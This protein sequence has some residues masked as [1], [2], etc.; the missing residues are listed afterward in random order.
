[1]PSVVPQGAR[2]ALHGS[3]EMTPL[4]F[5]A[6]RLP[7]GIGRF[8]FFGAVYRSGAFHLLR[9]R[10]SAAGSKVT[11]AMFHRVADRDPDDS[12][13][14]PTL[15]ISRR[16]F[17]KTIDFLRAHYRIISLDD[18]LEALD[19]RREL[20]PHSMVL[21]FDDAYAD[22]F[23]NAV[24]ALAERSVPATVFVPT[25]FVGAADRLFWW[26]ECYFLLRR[27]SGSPGT[28]RGALIRLGHAEI[29]DWLESARSRPLGDDVLSLVHTLQSMPDP[30][31]RSLLDVLWEQTGLPRAPLLA[32]NAMADWSTI[33]RAAA[34][35]IT[36]GSH[37]C[38]HLF[39]DCADSQTIRDE[40]SRSKR[41]I[42]GQLDRPVHTFAYPGGKLTSEV[43]RWVEEAG[44][45][46]GVTTEPGLNGLGDSPYTLK[47]ISIWNGTVSGP[48]GGFSPGRLAFNL[49][50]LRKARGDARRVRS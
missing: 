9:S 43:E 15:F 30:G 10:L 8:L 14:L 32:C 40:L 5:E 11:I 25:D 48:G 45:R 19:G 47:R 34:D 36:Y 49:L 16:R 23:E 33:R 27:L 39:L 35:G 3:D 31:R 7:A 13:S 28:V 17:E 37:T 4:R 38:S 29:V 42:E 6:G 24:P 26:D 20:A 2:C 44:Y 46:C 50:A 22:V 41:E 12:Y 1:M 18:L 21:T